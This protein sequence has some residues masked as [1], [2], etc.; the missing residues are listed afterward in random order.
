MAPD[1]IWILL[2]KRGSGEA[3]PDELSELESLLAAHEGNSYTSE[4]MEKIW[5]APLV[6]VPD[7]DADR[8]VWHR[9]QKQVYAEAAHAGRGRVLRLLTDKWMVAASVLLIIAA[10]AAIFLYQ[11]GRI[12]QTLITRSSTNHVDTQ[13]GSRTKLELPD[14]TQVW[15][16]ANSQL[17]Y[18]GKNFGT[19]ERDVSLSGEAFFDVAK[20]E[21]IPFIIHTRELTI[22]VMGTAFNV[23][24]YPKERTVETALIRGLVE[25][26]TRRDPD[27]KILLKPDEK[28]IV[29]VDSSQEEPDAGR[30]HLANN[31][32]SSLYSIVKLRKDSSQTVPETVWMKSKL[33]FDNELFADLAP[34]MENWFNIRIRFRDEGIKKRRFS[35]VIEKETLAETLDAMKISGRFSYQIKGNELWIGE[36]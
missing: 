20:N 27:R 35:G 7:I 18:G 5:E 16:N 4:I 8:G 15:L 13:P 14:G 34:K 22:T 6:P 33:E 23:R 2:G 30:G 21:K 11:R 26:T 3:T 29:P 25:I 17:V 1:R 9:I 19:D 10:S 32:P 28:I 12:Q 31:T 24:A 36:N